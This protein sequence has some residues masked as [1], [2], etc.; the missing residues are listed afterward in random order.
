MNTRDFRLGWEFLTS[1]GLSL[2]IVGLGTWWVLA[3]P[4]QIDRTTSPEATAY[5]VQPQDLSRISA[6]SDWI[7]EGVVTEVYPAVWTTPDRNP[8]LRLAESFKDPNVQIRTPVLLEVDKV[9]KGKGI[10]GTVLFT[11]P[12]GQDGEVTVTSPFGMVPRKGDR[13]VTFL[14]KAPENSGPWVEIS[15]LYP[16]LFFISDGDA[17][18]GP[19]TTIT[20]SRLTAQLGWGG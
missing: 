17:L 8:P 16:Q 11:L 2:V 3:E 15:P 10:P 6:T 5:G 4:L 9:Y 7:V 20:R 18:E 14:S 12:G 1:A 13:I 19:T